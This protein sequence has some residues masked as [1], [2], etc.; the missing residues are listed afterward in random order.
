MKLEQHARLVS[1]T[2]RL[3]T[4]TK[5]ALAAQADLRAS[6]QYFEYAGQRFT[7]PDAALLKQCL[8]KALLGIADIA[9][10]ELKKGGIEMPEDVAGVMMT[11]DDAPATVPHLRVVEGSFSAEIDDADAQ[12]R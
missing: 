10:D 6:D 12:R 3:N 8:I 9:M 2:L 7:G 1:H 11:D 4:A 5:A